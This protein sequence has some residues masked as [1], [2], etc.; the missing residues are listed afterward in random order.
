MRILLTAGNTATMIDRVRC[1]TNVFSGRTGA[2]IAV[3]AAQRG[4]SVDVL[5]SRPEAVQECLSGRSLSQDSLAIATYHS[6]ADLQRLMAERL[7][8]TRYGAVIHCAAVSDY[9]CAGVF[10]PV[11]GTTFDAATNEWLAS[12]SERPKLCDRRAGKVSSSAPELWLRMTPTPKLV[13]Q[14]RDPWDFA[15]VLVKFKLEVDV[16][17]EHLLERA[18]VSRQQSKADLM[19][20]NS[21]EGMAEWAFLGPVAGEYLRLA[22]GDLAGRLVDEIEQLA[23]SGTSSRQGP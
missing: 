14:I 1:V 19:V 9:E 2:R 11:D 6:F 3:E 22:R 18:E 21:L 17:D 16:P 20:A 4:H 8:A 10:A 5:T 12:E 23:E 13:D 7:S 15:G